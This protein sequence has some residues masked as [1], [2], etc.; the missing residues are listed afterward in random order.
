M[1]LI[2]KNSTQNVFVVKTL[3]KRKCPSVGWCWKGADPQPQLEA[4]CAWSVCRTGLCSVC[5]QSLS[6]CVCSRGCGTLPVNPYFN[7]CAELCLE[8]PQTRKAHCIPWLWSCREVVVSY[9]VGSGN[10]T[11][12]FCKSSILTPSHLSGGEEH[13]LSVTK[14]LSPSI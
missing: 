1:L 4:G 3:H 2:L 11:W 7:V 9:W 5:C 12:V 8:T 13:K 6:S 14:I 10:Q